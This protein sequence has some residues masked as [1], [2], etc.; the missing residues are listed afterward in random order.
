MD[1]FSFGITPDDQPLD[2]IDRADWAKEI[3]AGK[4]D[5]LKWDGE[6]VPIRMMV[7]LPFWL[8]IPDSEIAVTHEQTTVLASILGDYAE[9]SEGNTFHDSHATVVYIGAIAP[10]KS[11]ELPP[12]VTGTQFP[13]FRY[14]KTVVSFRPE[15]LKEA[16]DAWH[17]TEAT[18]PNR[19]RRIR[20]INQAHQYFCSLAFAHIPFLNHLITSYRSIS[21]DPFAVEVSEWDVPIWFAEYGDTLVRIGIVPYRENDTYP[22]TRRMGKSERSKFFAASKE[23]V[24]SQA[25][26]DVTPGKLELLDALGLFFRGRFGGAVRSAVTAIEVALEAQLKKRLKEKGYSDEEAERR[27]AET[28]NSFQ[29]RLA[30]YEKVSQRRLPSPIVSWIPTINGVRLKSELGWVRELRH[31][32]VHEGVRVD[33]FAHGPMQRAVETMTWL[34]RWLSCEDYT[35]G[36]NRNFAYFNGARGHILL[37]FEYTAT[38]IVVQPHQVNDDDIKC[39]DELVFEQYIASIAEFPCDVELFVK[40]SLIRLGIGVADAP[41]EIAD[42]PLLRETYHINHNGR[43]SLVF[44]LEF[45]GLIDAAT[46]G[47]VALRVLAHTRSCGPGWGGLCIVHHQRHALLQV[48][49]IADAI[50]EDVNRIATDSGLTLITTVDLCLLM[51]GGP[52][53]KWTIDDV[54]D[55]LF[56]PGRQC[57]TPPAYTEIGRYLRFYDRHSAMSIQLADGEAVKVGS[58]LGIRLATRYYEER[59]ES[60]QIEHEPVQ[61]AMGPCNVGIK[62]KLR[63]TDLR[64]GQPVYV[65]MQN[66]STDTPPDHGCQLEDTPSTGTVETG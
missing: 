59:I 64:A 47:Q 16:F 53:Y 24:Q 58:T 61:A 32:V 44:C 11:G 39:A 54:R 36:D 23:A 38:G 52:M 25:N 28:R 12:P 46:V 14:M 2:L 63:K 7:E 15:G 62:T 34:F 31:K 17:E 45:D 22:T 56:M 19:N 21:Y 4:A 55:S 1:A 66:Q 60:L 20:R 30:D 3:E 5:E 43:Q 35:P 42:D 49:E 13:I 48:R 40:T 51:Q 37:P 8:M 26:V 9:V 27:L 18:T 57:M 41:P 29:D 33:V 6:R 65:R 50:S 10:L